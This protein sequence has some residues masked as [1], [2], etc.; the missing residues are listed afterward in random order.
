MSEHKVSLP[1][2]LAALAVFAVTEGAAKAVEGPSITVEP[3]AGETK[4]LGKGETRNFTAKLLSKSFIVR[5]ATSKLEFT[6]ESLSVAKGAVLLGQQAG[7]APTSDEI[8]EISKGCK[9]TEG[10]NT[11]ASIAEPIRTVPLKSELVEST[12]HKLLML[13]K[14]EVGKTLTI[15]TLGAPCT[16]PLKVTGEETAEVLVD[17]E[18]GEEAGTPVELGGAKSLAKSWL[19]RLVA[20]PVTKVIKFAGGVETE[21]SIGQLEFGGWPGTFEGIA[22]IS[23]ANGKGETTG[24]KWSPLA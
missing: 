15:L 7:T 18:K 10:T 20:T 22:L 3:K 24:E 16:S 13:F 4:R 11:C 14:P 5:I 19:L 8:L 23:L 17:P 12:G 21:T 1:A 2:I 6:C 9:G